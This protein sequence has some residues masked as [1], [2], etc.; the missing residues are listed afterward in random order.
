MPGSMSN[1]TPFPAQLS[2]GLTSGPQ[3]FAFSD[4]RHRRRDYFAATPP[5][6]RSQHHAH[7]PLAF[8]RLVVDQPLRPEPPHRSRVTTN[9]Q[10]DRRRETTRGACSASGVLR[11]DA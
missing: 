10:I 7:D 2:P 9:L 5:R 1:I 3:P 8:P 11:E 4:H 6:S